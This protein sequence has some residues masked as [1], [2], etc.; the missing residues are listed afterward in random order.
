MVAGGLEHRVTAGVPQGSKFGSLFR[1][2]TYDE[3]L[4]L[5]GLPEGLGNVSVC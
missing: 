2:L 5:Q 4:E 1:D 3:A